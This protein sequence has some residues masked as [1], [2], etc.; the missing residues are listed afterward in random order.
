MVSAAQHYPKART[1]TSTGH[2]WVTMVL[3]RTSTSQVLTLSPVILSVS[4]EYLTTLF[5]G[6]S[7]DAFVREAFSSLL[8]TTEVLGRVECVRGSAKRSLPNK[9]N[10]TFTVFQRRPNIASIDRSF[11][12]LV[13]LSVLRLVRLQRRSHITVAHLSSCIRL[14]HDQFS[15]SLLPTHC[16]N[17]LQNNRQRRI[18]CNA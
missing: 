15:Q 6:S 7:C 2:Q 4:R 5:L 1:N 3:Q 11:I 9:G 17:N 18:L 12:R 8:A 14:Q 13:M 10:T 16:D